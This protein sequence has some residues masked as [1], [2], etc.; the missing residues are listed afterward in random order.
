MIRTSLLLGAAL[1]LPIGAASAA[2]ADRFLPAATSAALYSPA[3][4]PGTPEGEAIARAGYV[5]EEYLLSG[6]ANIYQQDEA[7]RTSIR[8]PGQEYTTRLV[9]VR[10]RDAKRFSGVVQ[11]GFNHPNF[12]NNQWLRIAPYVLRSGDIY[13]MLMIGGDP[14]SRQ[15]S[16][17]AAPISSPL[18]LPWFDPARYADIR[19]PDDGIRWDVIGQTILRLRAGTLPGPMAGVPARQLYMSGWSYL[20]SLQRSY[21]N[22]GFH[23]RYRLPDGKPAVDGYLIGISSN[24]VTAGWTPINDD[25]K[26]P[27]DDRRQLKTIDVPVVE[28][29]SQNEGITNRLPQIGDRDAY[30]G[31]HRIY[32][33]GG[34]SHT[35]LGVPARTGP[36]ETQLIAHHDSAYA[37]GFTCRTPDTDVPMRDLAAATLDN[38]RRWHDRGIAPPPSARLTLDGSG[39]AAALDANGNALGGVRAAQ[40]DVPLAR[41]GAPAAGDCSGTARYL[42]MRRNP[43]P[44]AALAAA[45]PGGRADYLRRFRQSLDRLV[46]A[47]RLL[48]PDADA[49]YA[50]A[51]A[52]AGQQFK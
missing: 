17:P 2:G 48:K 11:L 10:P 16:T 27:P 3:A 50:R 20:G 21:I 23:D 38:L 15:R 25:D 41:Y 24:S 6:T 36:W 18:M 12:G 29:M 43:L 9:I 35:D 47:R 46:G 14:G 37:P 28:L 13:A 26:V 51:E 22:W 42:V 7:G 1:L 40:L 34:V 52:F 49:Q 32:E 30:A 31:G 45:Y 8:T 5:Q 19:W 39:K 44:A 4:L 33:V